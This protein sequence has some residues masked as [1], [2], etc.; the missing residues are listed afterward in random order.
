MAHPPQPP[1]TTGMSFHHTNAVAVNSKTRGLSRIILM[2]IADRCDERNESWPSMNLLAQ[3]ANCTKRSVINALK[4]IPE[5]ELEIFKRGGSGRGDSN[6]YRLLIPLEQERVKSPTERVKS[7]SPE[8]T[9]TI[10]KESPIVPKGDKKQVDEVS[11]NPSALLRILKLFQIPAN[12]PVDHLTRRAYKRNQQAVENLSEE[13]WELLEWA[14]SQTKGESYEFRRKSPS[15]L[16]SNICAEITRARLWQGKNQDKT[17]RQRPEPNGWQEMILAEDP[18]FPLT[19]WEY[20]P[21][22]MKTWVQNEVRE[23]AFPPPHPAVDAPAMA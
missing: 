8:L 1:R 16:I 23:R 20:L 7:D 19:P 5:A 4:K 11:A 18:N 10:N 15:A 17:P 3:E 12:R 13:E 9:R 6:R 22:S 14:Y 21:Q 2:R